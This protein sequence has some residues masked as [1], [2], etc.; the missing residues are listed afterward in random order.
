MA[1]RYFCVW[2]ALQEEKYNKI[3]S[4]NPDFF[5]TLLESSFRSSIAELCKLFESPNAKFDPIISAFTIDSQFKLK[6][7]DQDT[8]DRLK[9][10]RDKVLMHNDEKIL[11]TPSYDFGIK[12]GNFEEL[13]GI[14]FDSLDKN[15]PINDA[16]DYLK[17]YR[18][19]IE[20]DCEDDVEKIM[21]GFL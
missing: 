14:L 21:S 10:Y 3:Y 8:V 7:R 6:Q 20:S 5:S 18:D 15:K 17:R 11:K 13:F 2:R 19:K 16:T 12:N 4:K 1:Y 9:F